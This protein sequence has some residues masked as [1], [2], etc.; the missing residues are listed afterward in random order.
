MVLSRLRRAAGRANRAVSALLAVLVGAAASPSA[1]VQAEGRPKA[2]PQLSREAAAAPEQT[3]RVLIGRVGRGRAVDAYV[4]GRGL[5]ISP[6]LIAP[7]GATTYT[8]PSG[9][10]SSWPEGGWNQTSQASPWAQAAVQ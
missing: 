1:P 5:R 3:F 10:T 9:T 2:L 6:H 8:T 4:T 7:N